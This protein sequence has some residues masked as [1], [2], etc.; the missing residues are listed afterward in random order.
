MSENEEIDAKKINKEQHFTTPPA[1]Y[2]EA[3][4]Y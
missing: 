2:T 4:T 1:R 3:K